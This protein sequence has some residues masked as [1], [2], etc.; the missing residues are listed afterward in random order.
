MHPVLKSLVSLAL[1]AAAAPGFACS[2]KF[3]V[4]SLDLAK[5]SVEDLGAALSQKKVTSVQLVDAYL[6]RIAACND[7]IRAVISTN[8]GALRAAK[9]RDAERAAGKVRG[10]MH[11]IPV[12]IKD[13]IDLEGAVT[14]AGSFALAD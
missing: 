13:N 10:P 12:I 5:T 3:R 14:T 7:E 9:E 6:K 11:G 4:G 2:D 8:R 1:L